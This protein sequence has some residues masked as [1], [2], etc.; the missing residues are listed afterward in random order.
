MFFRTCLLIFCL[1]SLSLTAQQRHS[2]RINWQNGAQTYKSPEGNLVKVKEFESCFIDPENGYLPVWS[3]LYKVP[4]SSDVIVSLENE[5]WEVLKIDDLDQDFKKLTSQ[6]QTWKNIASIRSENYVDVKLV[7]FKLEGN[8]VFI[9]KSGTWKLEPIPA[10]AK[11]SSNSSSYKN[12]SVLANGEWFKIRVKEDGIH[13]ITFEDLESLGMD[14]SNINPQNIRLFG[15][16]GGML[17]E[18]NADARPDDLQ[19][20][21]IYVSGQSDGSFDQGDYILFNG[22]SPHRW[23][24]NP[25]DGRYNHTF[26]IYSDYTYYFLTTSLGS[27]KRVTTQASSGSGGITINTFEDYAFREIDEFNL[28]KSGRNF[29]GDYLN[30]A[31]SSRTFDFSFPNLITS[32][33][34]LLK[35]SMVGR[36]TAG[37]FQVSISSSG[38]SLLTHNF[39][40][41]NASYTSTYADTETDLSQFSSNSSN[42]SLQYSLANANAEA[43]L[44]YLELQVSRNLVYPGSQTIFRNRAAISN[45]ATYNISSMSSGLMVWDITDPINVKNQ[46]GQL[47]GSTFSYTLTSSV[48]KEFVVFNPQDNLLSAEMVGSVD[49]QNLHGISSKDMIIITT[50]DFYNQA[51]RLATYHRNNGGLTVNTVLV[52][53]IYN[54]FSS[55]CQDISAIRDFMKMLYDKANGNIDNLPKYLLLFGDASYDYKDIVPDNTNFVPTYQSPNSLSPIGSFCSDDYFGFYD[56]SEG[57]N[58]T[59]ANDYMD[60][61]IGRIPCAD[62]DEAKDAVDKIIHYL[63]SATLGNWRN[64][65]TFVA[66]DEDGKTHIEDADILSNA[67]QNNYPAYNIDKIY[68]DAY[69]QVSTPGGNRYPDVRNAIKS[70][71]KSGTLI[72]NYTGHGGVNGWA[73]ERILQLI[74]ISEFDNFDKMPLF[75]TATCEFS[76]YDDPAVKSAGEQLFFN[77]DGGAISMVTTVRLVT[78]YAN[79]QI[80]SA[81]LENVF[82]PFNGNTPTL[83]ETVLSSKNSLVGDGNEVNNRKFVLLGDPAMKLNYPQHNV[84]TNTLNGVDI[85]SNI[86]TLKALSKITVTGEVQDMNGNKMTNF[87]GVV[88]PTVF[89]KPVDFTTLKNDPDSDIYS[90]DVQKSIIFRGRSSVKNGEFEYSFIVP[91]DISYNF[92]EGK[93]SYYADNGTDDAHGYSFE[94]IVGGTA[95]S[96]SEDNVPPLL[97]VF[98]ND[99]NFVFGGV[100]NENPLLLVKL[101]DENGINTVSTGIGHDITAILDENTSDAIVLNEYYEAELNSYSR[102]KVSYPMSELEEGRHTLSVKAWD[103]YNNPGEGYTEFIVASSAELALKHVLNYPNPFTTSTNFQFE[104]NR[105]G[106]MLLVVLNIFTVS[107]KL[108]KTIRQDILSDSFRVDNIHWDGLDDFGD[109]IG[110]GAYVY[111]LSVRTPNGDSAHKFEKLVILR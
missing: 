9:L 105:P 99:E 108:V 79:Y 75:I 89:D 33:P 85:N 111:K 72:M 80:N 91:K 10:Y 95:D 16:G 69:Q 18:E 101:M 7:P 102:G 39:S 30:F 92:G 78:S 65:I 62:V 93:L 36:Y 34:V 87:N 25:N 47:S 63:S 54:E 61:A 12:N 84:V 49:N 51:E 43:W 1:F 90:F 44:D 13:K 46:Q 70:K 59:D 26:N 2:F 88:Y 38:Q 68:L 81:F 94:A 107:G 56:N 77:P 58:I 109:E 97:E 86:D 19:E 48:L 40:K 45:T 67:L 60:I 98:M 3:E 76:K 41:V 52:E 64:N 4:N 100:T 23:E 6:P 82:E 20:N 14:P 28:I 32:Q 53:Q 110:R 50:P 74:D 29:Y 21:A 103:V 17:P 71:V 42:I 37:N 106:E 66:D 96:I 35:S 27:G 24:Y 11:Q 83:G 22:Q 73:H 31:T 55:G 104:H 15:N 5:V 8:K 57:G